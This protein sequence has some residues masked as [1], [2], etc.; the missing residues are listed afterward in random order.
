MAA[1]VVLRQHKAVQGNLPM[2]AQGDGKNSGQHQMEFAMDARN[3]RQWL[4]NPW[5]LADFIG[6]A[7]R[8]SRCVP[9][10]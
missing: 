4:I 3:L 7:K 9:F 6:L 10:P 8:W 1:T 2:S 5:Q